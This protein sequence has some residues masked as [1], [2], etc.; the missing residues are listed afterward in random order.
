MVQVSSNLCIVQSGA[1]KPAAATSRS[2]SR[3][4]LIATLRS[5]SALH[6]DVG[7]ATLRDIDVAEE[8]P[9]AIS[10]NGFAHAVMLGTP[11]DLE[12]FVVGFSLAEGIISRPSDLKSI[13]SRPNEDGIEI[14]VAL[15]PDALHRFLARRRVR[16]LPGRT[17]C[18]LCGVEDLEQLRPI[19]R[20]ACVRPASP[21]DQAALH[22]AFD[23]LRN[24][25]PLSRLTHAAHAAAWADLDG[26]LRIVREDVG[27]HNALDK[28]VG[29][30]LR[31]DRDLAD[32]FCLITS[33]CSYEMVQK[34]VTAG[35]ATLAA[36]SAPTAL[37]V[38]MARHA[39]L[40]LLTPDR[41]GG[42][43]I[44]A[45]PQKVAAKNG[46]RL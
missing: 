36:V 3:E 38:R 15:Q 10:Y 34:A 4:S 37:A 31:S 35:I 20:P 19:A 27:R 18:G 17:S 45:A 11:F 32:G 44:Y 43:L 14:A 24:Y 12:D 21:P 46:A 5:V 23:G 2:A 39:G 29:A 22:A 42:F 41:S 33:R 26:S 9:L 8:M 7:D 40:I 13:E 25:Q 1:C 30:A 28:L 6:H 16:A